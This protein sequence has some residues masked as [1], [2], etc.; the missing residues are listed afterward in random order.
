MKRLI[1][2][3]IAI[4]GFNKGLWS[5]IEVPPKKFIFNTNVANLLPKYSYHYGEGNLG[6]EY[7]AGKQI[8][9]GLN[10]GLFFKYNFKDTLIQEDILPNVTTKN[11]FGGSFS[12]DFKRFIGRQIN[13]DEQPTKFLDN[14]GDVNEGYYLGLSIKERFVNVYSDYL[15]GQTLIPRFNDYFTVSVDLYFGRQY[16][17]EKG[18]VLDH[19]LGLGFVKGSILTQ[20]YPE[21]AM[22]NKWDTNVYPNLSYKLKLGK[23]FLK[24]FVVKE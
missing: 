1:I 15:F 3:F 19:A 20:S 6:F 9:V 18:Y 10:F 5:Q 21:Y 17:T 23:Q 22:F 16:I 2:I 13:K 24:E 4:I 11:V 7:Y 14:N 12:I 8:S